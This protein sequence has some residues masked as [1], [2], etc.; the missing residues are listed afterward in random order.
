MYTRQ[1]SYEIADMGMVK[2]FDRTLMVAI[3]HAVI[4]IDALLYMEIR[5]LILFCFGFEGLDPLLEYSKQFI[6]T[7]TVR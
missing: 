2:I 6:M 5:K 4:R 1:R 7:S 3:V